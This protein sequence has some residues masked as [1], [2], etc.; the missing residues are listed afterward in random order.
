MPFL[1]RASTGLPIE[2][3]SFWITA[4]RRPL[5]IQP[6]TLFNE[7][8]S[9]M[10]FYLWADL[11]GIDIVER[12]HDGTFFE[13]SEII[14]LVNT[15]GW[16]LGDL[17]SAVARRSSGLTTLT[18]HMPKSGVGSGEKRNRLS[19]VRSF[20][21]FT[22]ADY[23][24]RLQS[25]PNRWA[26]YRDMR[27]ECLGHLATYIEGLRAPKREDVGEREGLDAGVLVLL[28]AVIDP[29]HPDNPFEPKARFRNFVMIRLLIEL[30][31]RRGEL[32]GIMLHDCDVSGPRGYI[33]IHRRPDNVLDRRIAPGAS[34]KTAAR[35]LE[36]SPRTTQLVYEWI[37]HYRSKLPGAARG[38]G[39]F[40]I[41]SI[42]KGQPMSP[43]N[44]NK[45]FEALRRRVPELPKEFSPHLLRHSWNDTFS[46]LIDK[47]GISENDE[48]KFRQKIMGWRDEASARFYLR[49]T[50]GRR[51]NE[52]LMEMHD[53]LDI[54]VKK[55][56]QER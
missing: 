9:L 55:A 31:I 10:V 13:L 27:V 45:I 11:Q 46:E 18:R 53:D 49:R 56:G 39:Q 32:L 22:S 41:V 7:L 34:T 51:A 40:L 2:A 36:L 26:L 37:V 8:R 30:G 35:K 21:E 38:K 50:V 5:G 52:V 23:L 6:N 47:K 14:D 20:L 3:P 19:V 24:S 29:D 44:V 43:S 28:C 16:K 12:L 54:R 25:W 4:H 15:C 48:V 17:L 33:T 1:V 42:P